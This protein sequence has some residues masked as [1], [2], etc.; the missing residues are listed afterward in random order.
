MSRPFPPQAPVSRGHN[1]DVQPPP[2]KQPKSC[3]VCLTHSKSVPQTSRTPSLSLLKST[4]ERKGLILSRVPK[5]CRRRLQRQKT[6]AAK[7]LGLSPTV[8]RLFVLETDQRTLCFTPLLY[9]TSSRPLQ[10]TNF[11]QWAG[12]LRSWRKSEEVVFCHLVV[13]SMKGGK[14][15][16]RRRQE[17]ERTMAKKPKQCH[18][19]PTKI[20]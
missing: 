7:W 2:E 8:S 9:G 4:E 6:K 20:W 12:R 10:G 5:L 17:R 19:I 18:H 3:P 16:K 13:V 11:N 14:D 1:A 15:N